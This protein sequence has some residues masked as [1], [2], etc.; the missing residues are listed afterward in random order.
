MENQISSNVIMVVAFLSIAVIS[1]VV[2]KKIRFPYT[3]GLVVVG[4]LCGLLAHYFPPLESI[5]SVE[6]SPEMI[7]Y[8]ILPTLIFSAAI[9]IDISMLRK[10]LIPILILAVF[11][12]LISTAI[13]S[14]ITWFIPISLGGA[15]VFGALISATD[16][17]AVI[18]LFKEIGAPKRLMTLVDGE[19][20]FNDATAIVLFTIILGMFTGSHGASP[21]ILGGV[22][23]FIVVL[24]GGVGLGALIGWAGSFVLRI[25]KDDLLLQITV[26]LIMAYVSFIVADKIHLSGVMSTLG[27]GLVFRIRTEKVIRRSNI[28]TME[29]FWDYFA[30]V[31]NS[32]VFLLLGLTEVHNFLETDNLIDVLKSLLVVIPFVLL[33]R[34]IGIFALIPIYNHFVRKDEKQKISVP[35]QTV[36]FWGGL[37]GAVPV[38]LMLAIPQDFADRQLIIHLTMGF[39]LFTLLIEG[40]TTKK[41]MDI[42][43]VCPDKTAFDDREVIRK[44]FPIKSEG[45][46]LLVFNGIRKLFEEE[47]FFVREKNEEIRDEMLMKRGKVTLL[48]VYE[49]GT[50]ALTAE[51][52][53]ISYL[54]TVLSETILAL[55]RSMNSLKELT[56]PEKMKELVAVESQSSSVSFDMMRYLKPALMTIPLVSS[57]KAGILKEML[58][59][60]VHR[61]AIKSYEEVMAE[62]FEREESMSTGIGMGIAIPHARSEFVSEMTVL[63][64]IHRQGV[65]FVSLDG[66]PVHIFVMIV[67]PKNDSGPHLQML[68]AVAR[69][70]MNEELRTKIV[71]TEDRESLYAL[72]ES[73][74]RES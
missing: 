24:A 26:S 18:A 38:A 11:T 69:L 16:P 44:E 70:L 48:V 40:T 62:V 7:L 61:G 35:Y 43:G 8:I 28:E 53:N 50:I 14:G 65:D 12:L 2:M 73:A 31:A 32:F 27:A 72:F 22:L 42:L 4:I 74:V 6:L 66:L 49:N 55:S 51:P 29:H 25:G 68:A 5:S 9:D 52:S 39:I 60:L 59:I 57:D 30:F 36:L 15:L 13:I 71:Q 47:G 64:G 37:R 3:I 54:T 56:N 45:L 41:L 33:A 19:S 21:D 67:S 46:A 58:Q 1:A 20:I 63:I 23:K 17:V 10:N 34:F